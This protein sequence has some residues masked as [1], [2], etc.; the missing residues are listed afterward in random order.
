MFAETQLRSLNH[1]EYGNAQCTYNKHT[2]THIHIAEKSIDCSNEFA[3]NATSA[4]VSR[5]H[6]RILI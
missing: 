1:I 2:H 6:K 5:V 4:S 3:Q